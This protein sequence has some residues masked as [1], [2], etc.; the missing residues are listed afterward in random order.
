[1]GYRIFYSYQSDITKK[2]NQKFIRDAIK[3]A[4]SSITQYQ[5][6]P[7]IEG[8]YGVSG[9]PP[10]AET[11]LEQSESSD[12]FIGD[13][14][15]TSSKIWYNPIDIVEGENTILIEIEKGDLKPSPNPNV[16]L[17]TGYSW[18]LKKYKRTILV[19]NTAFGDPKRLPVDMGGI[20]YPITY[21]LSE[22]R[23]NSASTKN[24]E[25]KNLRN[26]LK[27]ALLD[28]LASDTE[29][30]RNKWNPLKINQDWKS[31]NF[32]NEY[33]V[34]PELK[35]LIF[36]LRAGICFP[37]RPQRIIGPPKS[38]KTR[39]ARE[40]LNEL[41]PDLPK[42]DM[43]ELIL[44][45]DL[46]STN[47]LAIEKPIRTLVTSGQHKIL[48]LD[49]CSLDIHKKI[50]EETYESQVRVVTIAN[51]DKSTSIDQATIRL[52]E[53]VSQ[54]ILTQALSKKYTPSTAN[55][56]VGTTRGNLNEGL[57][58]LKTS[59]EID[60]KIDYQT[61]WSQ[62]LGIA[63]AEN[64]LEV[65]EII[66]IFKYVGTTGKYSKQKEFLVSS[67]GIEPKMFDSILE[68][69][70]GIGILE[71]KG[72]FIL[73]ETFAEELALSWWLKQNQESVV[74][75]FKSIAKVG[76]S[77][78]LGIRIIELNEKS[79]SKDVVQLV[80]GAGQVFN[81][82]YLNS[83]EGSRLIMNLAEIAPSEVMLSLENCFGEKSTDDLLKF[84]DGR[85]N[86]VW[87]LEKLCFRTETFEPATKLMFRLAIAE[88]E[89][90]GNNSTG[91][92][93]QLFQPFLAGTQVNL[94]SRFNLLMELLDDKIDTNIRL[95][96]SAV[97][98][99]LQTG[100][101]HRTGGAET[102]AGQRLEDHQPEGKELMDY[103]NN[104]IQ[105]LLD[106]EGEYAQEAESILIG[107]FA[108]QYIDGNVEVIFKS[109][110]VIIERNQ[111][112]TPELRQRIST[113]LSNRKITGPNKAEL[114]S[115]LGSNEPKDLKSRLSILVISA[116]YL[117]ENVDGQW[118]DLAAQK[119]IELAQEIARNT[120]YE[121][122]EYLEQLQRGEQRQ[123][124]VFALEIGRT[125]K[126]S[127]EIINAAIQALSNIEFAHQNDFFIRGFVRGV[128]NEE[129]T[130][131][132]I[133]KLLATSFGYHSFRL[134]GHLNVT[135]NDLRKL[136]PLIEINANYSLGFQ[137]LKY[138]NLSKEEFH[139]F[140]IWM[141]KGAPLQNL[142]ALDIYDEIET[143][144]PEF[145]TKELSIA[146]ISRK[147]LIRA[148]TSID[149]GQPFLYK[150]EKVVSQILS[151]E[152][153][154]ETIQHITEDIILGCSEIRM[155]GESTLER[156]AGLLL[157]RHWDIVWPAFSNALI[158]VSSESWSGVRDILSKYKNYDVGKLITW[159]KDQDDM[160]PIYLMM[161]LSF[162]ELDG[163]GK[164][165]WN[166]STIML[167]DNYGYDQRVLEEL[168]ANL[169][170]FS[171]SGSA[172]DLLSSRR[173]MLKQLI[174][175]Q[176]E[177]VRDFA[178][179]EIKFFESDIRRER[180][181]NQNYN[182]G[183]GF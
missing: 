60:D 67:L 10:L 180:I 110:K 116:S 58:Y 65:L 92:F 174:S 42:V 172:I 150:Y 105:F 83:E 79:T 24:K 17:E 153:G 141:T 154:T 165:T 39:L 49:N 111:G 167:L 135:F 123:T 88:N 35:N 147:G 26:S 27:L 143:S 14:T 128:D 97:G 59:L 130:R 125:F 25:F 4:I 86:L 178:I 55:T 173:D 181:F 71:T 57:L 166:P 12:I 21:N 129:F 156:I 98:R 51:Y 140:I 20:R 36:Q 159:L 32:Q 53:E 68:Y 8:F 179:K 161:V 64:G 13:M 23:F 33:H 157:D 89:N 87:T 182:L 77:R 149:I 124:Y 175:H 112:L 96:I 117:M 127:D 94:E 134:S 100:H 90:Y 109:I 50:C 63:F 43:L 152:L 142:I 137:Y 31:K 18:A 138:D 93:K 44:Y 101:Y 91:Q 72:D 148:M 115:L 151:A 118:V 163:Q 1:M 46:N 114:V 169:H 52:T 47:F 120:S 170:S 144:K 28:V 84:V 73:I 38:G 30:Q 81:Y 108:Q 171:V 9:N 177:T 107:K 62:I 85:R 99:G 66:A 106:R 16:L 113:M 76:L 104:C 155:Q 2:L 122:F 54:K 7:L 119:A 80:L 133:D 139:D 34:I 15:F 6:E 41:S 145:Q 45:Y 11:M 176:K 183:E 61:K 160:A 78:S 102:Q 40:M 162:E 70:L 69:S 158:D 103:W 95:I 136:M 37:E 56:I 82:D 121:W 3:D 19:M 22:E 131:K 146:L 168:S 48:I 5:I 74:A 29:Y 126:K 164:S 132:T 75:L